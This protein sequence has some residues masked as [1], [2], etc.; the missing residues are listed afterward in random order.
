MAAQ[1]ADAAAL[2]LSP[3]GVGVVLIVGIANEGHFDRDAV[4]VLAGPASDLAQGGGVVRLAGDVVPRRL[5]LAPLVPVDPTGADR[6]PRR[7][8]RRL[9]RGRGGR[10]LSSPT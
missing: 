8:G 5:P 6:A 9:R 3:E 1:V 10:F 4:A 2:D 7:R